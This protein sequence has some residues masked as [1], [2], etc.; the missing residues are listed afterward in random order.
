MQCPVLP[1]LLFLPVLKP[2]SETTGFLGDNAIVP[3]DV[4][5]PP[6]PEFEALHFALDQL[7]TLQ[8]KFLRVVFAGTTIRWKGMHRRS[9]SMQHRIHVSV[10]NVGDVS[11]DVFPDYISRIMT[12][13][14]S[15][16]LVALHINLLKWR[17][18]EF[19]ELLLIFQDGL[20][21]NARIPYCNLSTR[22]FALLMVGILQS[23]LDGHG[24]SIC[25]HGLSTEE[26]EEWLE[27]CLAY[28]V[29]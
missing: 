26:L 21:S 9:D 22:E 25:G 16:R 29:G 1:F 12:T 23:E 18:V 2:S 17:Q 24:N 10:P 4:F 28:L 13:P 19:D 7:Y 3:I 5:Y 14:A 20:A 8:E 27:F 15:E 11:A 6:L